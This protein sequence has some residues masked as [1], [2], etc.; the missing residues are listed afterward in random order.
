MLMIFAW[1]TDGRNQCL[2]VSLFTFC[3]PSA[4]DGG[5]A[6]M[7]D[8]FSQVILATM[9]F[10]FLYIYII[11]G[12]RLLYWQKTCSGFSSNDKRVSV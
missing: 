12:K 8:E 2:P 11:E 9:G 7:W 5:L 4:E 6:G 10:V 3:I 1:L